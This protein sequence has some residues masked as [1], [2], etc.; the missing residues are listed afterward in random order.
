MNKRKVLNLGLAVVFLVVL[1]GF[2]GCAS[3]LATK[4]RKACPLI[5]VWELTTVSSRGTRTRTLTISEDLTGTYQ[6]RNRE[7]PITELKIEGEQVSFKVLR[8][9]REREFTMEFKAILDGEILKGQWIT[10][11]GSRDVTGKKVSPG[12]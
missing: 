11:R 2:L 6:G 5:G 7:T 9:F 3:D 1:V 12:L 8:K 4:R 10:P